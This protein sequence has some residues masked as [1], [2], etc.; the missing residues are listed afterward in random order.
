MNLS[1][2]LSIIILTYNEEIHIKRC[3]ES[4]SKISDNI[5]IF[6]IDSNSTDNTLRIAKEYTD[7]IYQFDFTSFSEKLNWAIN[8]LPIQTK[9]TMRIDADEIL[10][11]KFVQNINKSLKEMSSD[12]CGVYLRRQLW[13]MNRWIK[14][15]GMYPTYSMRIWKT[16]QVLCENRLLDEHM[17][18]RQGNSATLNLDIIDN[19]LTSIGNWINKHN[20]Y[21][22]LEMLSYFENKASS[23]IEPKLFGN[24]VER[25]RWL[26]NILFY[27]L[28]SFVRPFIYFL[29][30]YIIRFGFMDGKEGFIWHV[31]HG[32]WYRFLVDVKVYEIEKKAKALN[33]P[34]E[35][36]IKKEYGITL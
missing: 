32:F 4:V 24:Q 19:P 15:G 16:K 9:W 28:P 10:T 34:I 14:Y 6:I 20:N 1:E 8:N 21:S 25:K 11:N 23:M 17:I 12:V 22:A 27:S 3:L 33:M 31:L 2:H 5:S 7:K 13:F 36:V 30:R 29:Y 18:L 26:K 35:E